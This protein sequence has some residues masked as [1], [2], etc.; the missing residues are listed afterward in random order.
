MRQQAERDPCTLVFVVGL[1]LFFFVR[2][3]APNNARGAG[4]GDERRDAEHDRGGDAVASRQRRVEQGCRQSQ[5]GVADDATEAGRQRPMG[6]ARQARDEC[7][8]Q[9]GAEQPQH[10]A[11]PLMAERPVTEQPVAPHRDRQQQRQRAEPEQLHHQIG[12]DGARPAEEIV[13]RC[14]G[15]VAQRRIVHRP[16]RERERRH[17]GEADERD[18]AH[19][20]QPPLQDGAELAGEEGYSVEAAVDQ[21]HPLRSAQPSIATRRCNAS[22]VISLFWTMATRT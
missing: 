12:G 10:D 6:A 13:H 7:G 2:R 5:H 18:P 4:E 9:Y 21:R 1:F 11:Q 19:L 22:A 17:H 14:V 15:R 3:V 20:A 8:R 16:G